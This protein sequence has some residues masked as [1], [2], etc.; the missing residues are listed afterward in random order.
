MDQSLKTNL[1]RPTLRPLMSRRSKSSTSR[2][3][4]RR[5]HIHSR[6]RYSRG[7]I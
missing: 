1:K 4:E 7:L 3:G 2:D 6:R 5:V